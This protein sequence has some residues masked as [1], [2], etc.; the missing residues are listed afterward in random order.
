MKKLSLIVWIALLIS[1][2]CL[3]NLHLVIDLSSQEFDWLDGTS[4]T[5]NYG[6]DDN[7]FGTINTN[8]A[9]I[10]S[11]ILVYNGKGTHYG[12]AFDFSNDLTVIQ[13]IGLYTTLPP[14]RP[15]SFTGT[16]QGPTSAVF[17]TGSFSNFVNLTLETYTLLPV[18]AGWD[19]GITVSIIPEP[20]TLSLFALG[21]M[22]AGKKRT[23]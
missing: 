23:V 11:P 12:V 10:S 1:S 22:L 19:G 2:N 16:A 14:G 4:I 17:S 9:F 5:R 8:D 6:M 18:T 3:A 21:A 13:G 7:R 15:A 20:A